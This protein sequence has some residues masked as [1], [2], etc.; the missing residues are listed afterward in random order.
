MHPDMKNALGEALEEIMNMSPEQ[1]KV[2]IQEHRGV[3]WRSVK[4]NSWEEDSAGKKDDICFEPLTWMDGEQYNRRRIVSAAN[5]YVL[6]DGRQIVVPCVRHSS[7]E[8]HANLA[9]L[10]EVGLLKRGV[11]F[12]DNQGF[13]DQYGNWWSR[14]EAFIIATAANQVNMD[15]NGSDDELYSEGLY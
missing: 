5:K 3:D 13:I 6:T 8:L 15:R 9:L 2:E 1:F 10:K 11:C 4:K 12:P 14:E 7:R